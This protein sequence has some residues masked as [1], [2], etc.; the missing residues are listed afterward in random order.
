MID[1]QQNVALSTP[2]GRVAKWIGLAVAILVAGL[3]L[4]FGFWQNMPAQQVIF[5]AAATFALVIWAWNS[6]LNG[7]L[8]ELSLRNAKDGATPQS[9]KAAFRGFLI[10]NRALLISLGLLL[11]GFLILAATL[12][13]FMTTVNIIVG[14]IL[15]LL[16]IVAV[17]VSKLFSD[18][19]SAFIGLT[20]LLAL[21]VVASLKINGFLSLGNI[22]SMLVFA[23]FL[24]L[25]CLGQTLVALLGGLDLSIPFIIG[26]ANVGLL[27]LLG[28]GV[29]SWLAVIL[30]LLL[31]IAIGLL[32]GFLS[33]R[34][35]GSALILTL[36]TGF[37]VSGI[38][39]ILTSIGT[40]FAGNVYGEVPSWL[41]NVASLNGTTFGLAVPA[42]VFIWIAVAI[43]L[44]Y[45]MK[46]T[47][48]GR[49]LYALGGNRTSA[50]RLSISERGYWCGAYAI[51]GGVSAL[52]GALFLGWSGGGFIG[53]GQP[54]LFMTLAA[55]V[56]GG[57]SLLGGYGGYGVTVI[58]VLVLQVLTSFL[59]G[60]GLKFEWQQFI[61]GLLIVPMVALYA[62]SPHIRT[63]V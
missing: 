33:F 2:L 56:I 47:I 23:S 53:V 40:A 50:Q 20:V 48:Y 52:T 34:L 25:A 16:L 42:V 24:G 54:Y 58:G 45:A 61:F 5:Y 31:G 29:P 32:N 57:T 17:K 6:Y 4:I 7:W 26:S 30:I 28:L 18:N 27:Y 14:L 44:I 22:K 63:Q 8:L 55:V 51:S 43:L 3:G 60:I 12:K 62:R 38:T 19:R 39:Q 13:N 59:V 1:V 21:F 41:R 46:N 11:L 49:N 35:Q 36:G 10:R 15:A 9:G 37:A